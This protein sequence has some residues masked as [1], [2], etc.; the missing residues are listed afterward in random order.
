MPQYQ[1]VSRRITHKYVGTYRHL[2][3]WEEVGTVKILGGVKV[4]DPYQQ[5]AFHLSNQPDYGGSS[6]RTK[7]GFKYPHMRP[8][9]RKCEIRRRLREFYA[10]SSVG[11]EQVMRVIA[12]GFKGMTSAEVCRAIE[13]EFSSHGC[14]H[15]Y[16]C[17]GCASYSARCRYT[18]KGANYVLTIRVGYNL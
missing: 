16:D 4:R 5:E 9:L 17:C 6:Y 11:D 3:Q 13:D 10:D 14:A 8:R 2:D 15:T 12:Y 7:H 18:G 1:R